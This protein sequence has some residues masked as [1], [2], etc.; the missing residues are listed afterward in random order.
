[1]TMVAGSATGEALGRQTRRAR[2]IAAWSFDVFAAV[3]GSRPATAQKPNWSIDA[4][5]TVVSLHASDS[6]LGDDQ[7]Q[8][9]DLILHRPAPRGHW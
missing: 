9:A 1:M 6:R 5:V 8:S 4:E 3:A 7:T 2:V